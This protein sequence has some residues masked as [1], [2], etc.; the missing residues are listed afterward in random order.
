MGCDDAEDNTDDFH[1]GHF[2]M[3]RV[4]T[5][6]A[7]IDSMDRSNSCNR[8]HSIGHREQNT[9]VNKEARRESRRNH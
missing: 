4:I 7:C 9:R 1:K 5:L 3:A 8:C 2:Q 6:E